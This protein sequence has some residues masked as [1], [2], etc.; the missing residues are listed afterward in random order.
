MLCPRPKN[1]KPR[2][3]PKSR[4]FAALIGET[5]LR[6]DLDRIHDPD[7]RRRGNLGQVAR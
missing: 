4:A 2:R 5:N 7:D 1:G 6:A 3:L